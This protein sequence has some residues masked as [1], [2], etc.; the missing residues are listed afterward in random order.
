[1]KKLILSKLFGKREKILKSYKIHDRDLLNRLI[2]KNRHT[3]S[4]IENWLPEEVAA[5][6]YF[7]YGV[8]PQIKDLINLDVGSEMTYT[9]L[10]AY[11]SRHFASIN[12]LELGV[13]I[14][15][16]FLQLSNVLKESKMTGFDIEN[17]NPV[18]ES[19]FN[20]DSQIIW[21]TIE[22]SI[23]KE[24]S[25]ARTYHDVNQNRIKYL[26]AD[27]WDESSWSKLK[28]EKFNIIFSD[29]LH[30]PKALLWEFDMIKKYG[31]LDTQFMFLWDDLN[32]GLENS[33]FEIAQ[34]LRDA[35]GKSV[36]VYFFKVNGWLG[37]NYPLQHDI[38]IVSNIKLS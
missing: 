6:S 24:K 16:N 29:A 19:H 9:D 37:K 28:G 12:Y 26:A 25:S 21:D 13:S 20:F 8:P 35:R 23:R 18:L 27:I 4:T 36:D 10:I 15:K 11:F 22:S 1:M 33:F 17:I 31:L 2:T 7:N 30:D 34:Q 3:L 38:G 14:G 5:R 32:H